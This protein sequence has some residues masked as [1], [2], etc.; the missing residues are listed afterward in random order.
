MTSQ[1]TF[2]LGSTNTTLVDSRLSGGL[3]AYV[4]NTISNESTFEASVR[5]S[6]QSLAIKISDDNERI[7]FKVLNVY[8]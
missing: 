5:N 4:K 8:I 1:T 2:T 7:I 3:V 6:S